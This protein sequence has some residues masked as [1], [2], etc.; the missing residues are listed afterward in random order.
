MN[1]TVIA[2]MKTHLEGLFGIEDTPGEVMGD[3]GPTF[4]GKEFA[5][6]FFRFRFQ[7]YNII[8]Q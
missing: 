8:T 1:V 4:N 6:L 2:S 7:T 5:L 3:N